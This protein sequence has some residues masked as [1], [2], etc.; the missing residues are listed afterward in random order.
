MT[1][2]YDIFIG[3]PMG[4]SSYDGARVRFKDHIGNI[5]QAAAHCVREFEDEFPTVNVVLHTPEVDEFGSIPDTVF[6]MI[7]FAEL[8]IL[9]LSANSPSV[10]YE[11]T[12]MHA[13]GI[14]I[15]PIHLK[16][17][18]K[19]RNGKLPF[20]LQHDYCLIME[21]F[22]IPSL[23]DALRPKIRAGLKLQILG[24]EQNNNPLTRYFGVPLID[25]S[26]ST[27]LA[28]GY[29]HNFIQ[30]L[31][32]QSDNVIDK[33]TDLDLIVVLKPESLDDTA[34]LRSKIEDLAVKFGLEIELV[35]A[36]DGKVYE[37]RKQVRG[38]M[39]I[40][41]LGRYIF[42]TPAPLLAQKSSPMHTKLSKMLA[43]AFGPRRDEIET[44]F[45][46]RQSDM[47]EKF[48]S[49]LKSLS[50]GPSCDPNLMEVKT[51]EEFEAMLLGDLS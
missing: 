21:N 10:M 39:V 2:T 45:R 16:N 8:G 19:K 14:P 3:G 17:K 38:Q 48:L 46:K 31:I 47:I 9:D 22:R 11:L 50:V 26:A 33:N 13:L 37:D 43:G 25:A 20:Y 36:K 35:G 5:E 41:K 30:H 40:F 49:T 4:D 12:L 27:G 34:R 18:V 24:G 6:N 42:D 15:I 32:H 23:I 44:V 51:I 7:S 28:T 1:T 29:F